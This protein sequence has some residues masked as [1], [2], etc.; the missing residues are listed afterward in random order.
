L[1]VEKV[2]RYSFLVAR[3]QEPRFSILQ[4]S[5]AHQE[6]APSNQQ[7]VTSN[8]FH[9]NKISIRATKERGTSNPSKNQLR[10]GGELHG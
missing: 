4:F 2:T 9:L 3:S 6:R 1:Q 10:K 7:P 5:L 8:Y